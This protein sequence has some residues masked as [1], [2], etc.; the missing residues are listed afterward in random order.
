[1]LVLFPSHCTAIKRETAECEKE[2]KKKA[3]QIIRVLVAENKD[4][5]NG[6]RMSGSRYAYHLRDCFLVFSPSNICYGRRRAG[7]GEE[8]RSGDHQW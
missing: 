4:E 3:R 8:L 7:G 5:A 6:D 2:S 1:M